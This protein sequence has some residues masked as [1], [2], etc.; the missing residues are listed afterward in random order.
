ML[1]DSEV[2]IYNKSVHYNS[3]FNLVEARM[4]DIYV[5]EF[6]GKYARPSGEEDKSVASRFLRVRRYC[7][8]T[9]KQK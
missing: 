9:N 4:R 6:S 5:I 2:F 1:N 7:I 8:K 3:L